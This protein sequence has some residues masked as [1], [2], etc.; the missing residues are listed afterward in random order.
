MLT[1]FMLTGHKL[2]L[3]ENRE[4][5]LIKYLHK[6]AHRQVCKVLVWIND[7]CGRTQPTGGDTTPGLEVLSL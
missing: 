2:Q 6:M 3:T 7:G 4:P 1:H 5:Q